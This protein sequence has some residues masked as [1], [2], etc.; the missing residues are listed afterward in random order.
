[1]ARYTVT[2]VFAV[3]PGTD[4]CGSDPLAGLPLPAHATYRRSSCDGSRMTITADFRSSRPAAVCRQVADAARAGWAELSGVD[5]G[6]PTSVRVRPLHP[7][8]PVADGAG[9]SR[10]YVWCPDDDGDGRLVLVDAGSDPT[11]V[12][13]DVQPRQQE[14][15]DDAL[16]GGPR[17]PVRGLGPFRTALPRLL[18]REH[19]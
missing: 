3:G 4:P 13:N 17:R 7:P 12:A 15:A 5:P 2:L 9:R 19:G 16:T 1:M 10:E 11:S 6:H 18:R 8:R 14:Q